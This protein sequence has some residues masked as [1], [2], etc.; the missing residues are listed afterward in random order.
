M[1]AEGFNRQ[2]LGKTGKKSV[3]GSEFGFRASFGFRISVF[4]FPHRRTDAI[5]EYASRPR[6][7]GA[8]GLHSGEL[9]ASYA[10]IKPGAT[11]WH[12]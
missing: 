10:R 3:P 12:P 9:V 5:R 7:G 2:A 1:E 4:G 6:C 11:G 8:A